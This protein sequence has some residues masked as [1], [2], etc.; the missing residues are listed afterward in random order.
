MKPFPPSLMKNDK[1][2]QLLTL[3][4]ARMETQLTA[5]VHLA[6]WT[7]PCDGKRITMGFSSLA[8]DILNAKVLYGCQLPYSK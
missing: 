5:N 3:M 8:W 4:Q 2:R 7:L 6:T 1:K